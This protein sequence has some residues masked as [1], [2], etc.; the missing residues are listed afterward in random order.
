MVSLR[1]KHAVLGTFLEPFARYYA[2][3]F[4]PLVETAKHPERALLNQETYFILRALRKLLAEDSN[5]IDVG[6]HI[7]LILNEFM[8]LAPRGQHIGVEPTPQKAAWLRRKFPKAQILEC[9]L[10]DKPG[11][12]VFH[13]NLLEPAFSAL[14]AVRIASRKVRN[15]DQIREYDVAVKTLDEIALPSQRIRLVKIDAEGAELLILKGGAELL[16]RDHPI[17]VFECGAVCDG[18]NSGDGDAIF[19]HLTEAAGYTI[20]TPLGFLCKKS[21]LTRELFNHARTYPATSFNFIALPRA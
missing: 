17:L 19:S 20:H 6:C 13:E 10:A 9:A 7:G 4:L 8:R 21:P 3:R 5:C 12:A 18:V 15:G 11:S 2:L 1:L 16:A 14:G